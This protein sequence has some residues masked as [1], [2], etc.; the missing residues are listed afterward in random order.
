MDLQLPHG[1][2]AAVAM[3]G[4]PDG[5][6]VLVCHGLAETGLCAHRLS[7]A[8][9]A[10]GLRII[11]PDRPGTGGSS[12]RRL[13]RITD[14]V[15][16]AT[17]LLDVLDIP[18]AQV[19]GISGGGAY[20]AAC[21]ARRP[22]RF[23]RLLLVTPLGPPQW[24]TLGMAPWQRRS[25]WLGAHA[26]RFGGWFLGRL[27]RL[28]RVAPGLY[29]RIVTAELPEPDRR[30]LARPDL[31]EDFLAGYRDAFRQGT[32]GVA[33]DLRLLTRPWGFDLGEIDVPAVV[34]HGDADTTV[35]LH[36][37][38]RYAAAIPGARLQIHPGHGHFSIPARAGWVS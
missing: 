36:H 16:E 12:P 31:R 32:G 9:H 24:P 11:A 30:A 10:Q 20:A 17:R 2:R 13:E 28:G 38:Q 15:D 19:L 7:A 8:A 23:R 21:A 5:T 18:T 22:D 29:F 35:P 34:H 27:A 26:P 33:Q 6:P 3:A 4:P 1:G 25:L 37:A 14:W